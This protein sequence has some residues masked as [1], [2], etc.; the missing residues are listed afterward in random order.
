MG[1]GRSKVVAQVH[2]M[3]VVACKEG[4]AH[5]EGSAE[6]G[7]AHMEDWCLQ[8]E[9]GTGD[10][11]C[12]ACTENEVVPVPLAEN[13]AGFAGS[14]PALAGPGAQARAGVGIEAAGGM[15]ADGWGPLAVAARGSK[16]A[17]MG[18]QIGSF[19]VGIEAHWRPGGRGERGSG[20]EVG[21][22]FVVVA[23]HLE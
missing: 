4:R 14:H 19:E 15:A 2:W 18:A 8:P 5:V 22:G 20:F 23:G 3:E 17:Q 9:A 6:Q 12:N 1:A 10:L 7:E 16:G 13:V 11:G 21:I